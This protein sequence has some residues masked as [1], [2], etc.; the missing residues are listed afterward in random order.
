MARSKTRS[1]TPERFPS[2]NPVNQRQ[3]QLEEDI[4]SSDESKI[5]FRYREDYRGQ[6]V[7]NI[8]GKGE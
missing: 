8:L 7:T 3:G 5:Q 1:R 4:S 2:T 6:I